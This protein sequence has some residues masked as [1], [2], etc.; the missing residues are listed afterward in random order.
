MNSQWKLLWLHTNLRFV[1]VSSVI[2]VSGPGP[3]SGSGSVRFNVAS[4][5]SRDIFWTGLD[6]CV[7]FAL[8]FCL[9]HINHTSHQLQNKEV[10]DVTASI[11]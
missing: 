7:A 1:S 10:I 3:G 4:V 8:L 6:P 11:G 2:S 5:R 9:F